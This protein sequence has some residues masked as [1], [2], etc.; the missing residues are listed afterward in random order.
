MEKENQLEINILLTETGDE[1]RGT[2]TIRSGNVKVG[3]EEIDGFFLLSKKGKSPVPTSPITTG[4]PSEI[5]EA[6]TRAWLFMKTND[7]PYALLLEQIAKSIVNAAE[8]A[9]YTTDDKGETT[10]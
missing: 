8:R 3:P 10:H 1:Q 9:D 7:D 5:R 2:I 6:F 4:L